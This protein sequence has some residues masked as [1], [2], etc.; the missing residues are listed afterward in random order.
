MTTADNSGALACTYTFGTFSNAGEHDRL[1]PRFLSLG[2]V[3]HTDVAV[4]G[5]A[6]CAGCRPGKYGTDA[7]GSTA[8]L[9]CDPGQSQATPGQT[10]CAPCGAGRYQPA[11]GEPECDACAPGSQTE[12]GTHTD[13][14]GAHPDAWTG[15][16]AIACEVCGVGFTGSDPEQPCA[17]CGTGHYQVS[18]AIIAG[19]WVAFF[20]R[21]REMIVRTG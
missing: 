19:I 15:S 13:T 21:V 6:D 4:A 14:A 2:C 12:D 18:R 9:E 1:Q 17:I 7:T 11:T 20:Q 8:C 10:S 5:A 3:S 16:G